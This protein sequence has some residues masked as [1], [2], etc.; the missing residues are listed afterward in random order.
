MDLDKIVVRYLN[1]D[2]PEYYF[3]FDKAKN[4]ITSR[5]VTSDYLSNT[6]PLTKVIK[7]KLQHKKLIKQHNINGDFAMESEAMI[8]K[9]HCVISLSIRRVY[10]H[11]C[12]V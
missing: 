6:K 8:S 3:K 10:L 7:H 12:R 2:G 4:K 9:I 5:D 11:C 1:D